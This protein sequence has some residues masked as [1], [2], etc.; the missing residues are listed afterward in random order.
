MDGRLQR[1]KNEKIYLLSAEDNKFKVFAQSLKE[2]T[3][4]IEKLENNKDK[5]TCTCMDFVMR[6]KT[7]KHIYFLVCKIAKCESKIVHLNKH[8]DVIKKSI[9]DNI[10]KIKHNEEIKEIE[11]NKDEMCSICYDELGE[12]NCIKC[13]SSCENYFHNNC[14][15]MWLKKANTCPLCRTIWSS[16]SNVDDA[17]SMLKI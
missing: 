1:G 8:L 13:E 7:C 14:M 5:M 17:L 3:I 12:S 6:K 16:S 15:S 9:F 4:K 11:Y 2:Y 10:K